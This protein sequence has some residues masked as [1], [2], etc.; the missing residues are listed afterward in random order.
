MDMTTGKS[1]AHEPRGVLI[2]P[3]LEERRGEL[4]DLR[5]RLPAGSSE[6]L[7]EQGFDVD[8]FLLRY[9][10]SF[11]TADLALEPL[12]ACL[13]WRTDNSEKLL[14]IKEGGVEPHHETMTRFQ[15]S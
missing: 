7:T 2:A 8:I 4:D 5:G 6:G 14:A 3:V 1:L 9:L 15:V 11:K 12:L 13:Q 10:M